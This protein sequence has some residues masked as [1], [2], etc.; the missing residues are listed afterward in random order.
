LERQLHLRD[1]E[2]N[3]LTEQSNLQTRA[4]AEQRDELLRLRDDVADLDAT[5]KQLAITRERLENAARQCDD[6]V[7]TNQ[8]L[9]RKVDELGSELEKTI[10]SVEEL[11]AQL[12]TKSKLYDAALVDY[13][14]AA[15]GLEVKNHLVKRLEQQLAEFDKLKAENQMLTVKTADL[16][17]HLQRVSGEHEDSLQANEQA[18]ATI[19]QL[20]NDVHQKTATIRALRRERGAIEGLDG[21]Q[22][23]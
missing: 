19:R 20:E 3:Q 14:H 18:Q 12:A 6:L 5:H 7:A 21:N 23:A 10:G 4:F 1:N 2:I 13:Q 9:E 17:S 22:A 11:D 15:E 8:T 16:V